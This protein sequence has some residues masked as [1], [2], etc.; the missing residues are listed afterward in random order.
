MDSLVFRNAERH[1]REYREENDLLAA[2]HD[3][4]DC[5][6]CEAFLQMGIDSFEWVMRADRAIR[7][8]N[9]D[10]ET[11]ESL[12]RAIHVLCKNWLVPCQHAEA[13]VKKQLDQGYTID[14]L[15]A[16]RE[17]CEEM[18][19]IV[20]FRESTGGETLPDAMIPLRDDALKAFQD[21]KTAEIFSDEESHH[22]AIS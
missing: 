17:R 11:F 19:A 1:V 13:W 12:D 16:F 15:D 21:G 14:N 22:G 3:A 6:N 2:H 8:A 5:L 20:K 9:H 18:R 7:A 10:H 4:M